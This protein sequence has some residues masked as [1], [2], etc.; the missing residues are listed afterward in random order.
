MNKL[1]HIKLLITPTLIP[2]YPLP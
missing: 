2:L 1:I